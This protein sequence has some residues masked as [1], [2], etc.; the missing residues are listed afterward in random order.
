[1][2]NSNVFLHWTNHKIVICPFG[3]SLLSWIQLV[4]QSNLALMLMDL[5]EWG[6]CHMTATLTAG[7][8]WPKMRE[9]GGSARA[10]RS[11]AAA[12]QG[13]I[14]AGSGPKFCCCQMATVSVWSAPLV[15]TTLTDSHQS[16]LQLLNKFGSNRG[17]WQKGV[18]NGQNG[19]GSG[20]DG[21]REN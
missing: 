2:E 21:S 3:N 13:Q 6:Q 14:G 7:G 4:P 11:A 5:A 16:L 10:G 18:G 15:A 17:R 9:P 12:N 19:A 8:S 20:R 1:M